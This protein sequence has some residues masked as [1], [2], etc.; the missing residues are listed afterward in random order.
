[1]WGKQRL[2]FEPHGRDVVLCDDAD[3]SVRVAKAFAKGLACSVIS[4]DA[5][6]RGTLRDRIPKAARDQAVGVLEALRLDTD[7]LEW[8]LKDASPLRRVLAGAIVEALERMDLAYP[9]IT[10]AQRAE[11]ASAREALLAG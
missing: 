9:V 1:M 8:R 11:L 6:V 10:P 2:S 5:D 4:G 7:A 3:Q